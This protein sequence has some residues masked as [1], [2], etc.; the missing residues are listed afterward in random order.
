MITIKNSK[1]TVVNMYASLAIGLIILISGTLMAVMDMNFINNEKA[2]IGLSFIPLGN[3][4]YLWINQIFIK[5]YPAKMKP[6]VISENDERIVAMQNEADSITFRILR[7]ALLLLYFGYTFMV[8]DDIF[9][10]PSWWIMLAFF[11]ASYLLQ[12]LLLAYYY[13]KYNKKED[14]DESF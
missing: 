10:A 9:E 14:T 4:L 2:V 8:P 1:R 3:A 7:Y 12:G 11:M 13:K 6:M 5:K